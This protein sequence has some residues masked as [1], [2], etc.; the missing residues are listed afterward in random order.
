VGAKVRAVPQQQLAESV[1]VVVAATPYEQQADALRASGKLDG[2]TVVEISNPLKSDMS[3]LAV[4]P[5]T[6]GPPAGAE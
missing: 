3:G 1:D 6:S 4:G 5:P 2:K